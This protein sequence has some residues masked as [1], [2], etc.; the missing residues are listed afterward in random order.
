MAKFS[1]FV[2]VFALL[3]VFSTEAMAQNFSLQGNASF[4]AGQFWVGVTSRA[5][6]TENL[7]ARASLGVALQRYI[8]AS[9]DL[10]YN[11]RLTEEFDPFLGAGISYSTFV[12]PSIDLLGGVNFRVEG[13]RLNA[14][15][16]Y[17]IFFAA[18][19]PR[20]NPFGLRVGMNFSL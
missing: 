13:F 5:H 12:G 8:R 14:E 11:F 9:G 2:L 10:V 4:W 18:E 20:P 15:A 16:T 3:F 1:I 7:T 17:S 6:L 19:E